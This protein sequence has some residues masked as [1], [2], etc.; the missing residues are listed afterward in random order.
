[1][2]YVKKIEDVSRHLEKD[3]E[4]YLKK[5]IHLEDINHN[6]SNNKRSVNAVYWRWKYYKNTSSDS[7][8]IDFSTTLFCDKLF[9]TDVTNDMLKLIENEL[10]QTNS[11]N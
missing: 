4:R 5:D 3:R 8:E 6:R 10:N 2:G 1:M 7:L 9:Q 11:Q